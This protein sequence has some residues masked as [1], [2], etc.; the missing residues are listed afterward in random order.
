MRHLFFFVVPRR[1]RS[2]ASLARLLLLRRVAAVAA[3]LAMA[4]RREPS[5]GSLGSCSAMTGD[6]DGEPQ[7]NVVPVEVS[8]ASVPPAGRGGGDGGGDGAGR[9]GIYQGNWGG[10]RRLAQLPEMTN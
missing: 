4:N 9:F 7:H 5:T 8:C 1:M 10:T 2:A 6:D 3:G